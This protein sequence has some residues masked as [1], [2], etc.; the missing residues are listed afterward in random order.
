M[1]HGKSKPVGPAVKAGQRTHGERK[2]VLVLAGAFA[3]V[4][5]ALSAM[6]AQGAISRS[7]SRE[8]MGASLESVSRHQGT[9]RVLH[10]RFA[11]W[12]ELEARGERLR[13]GLEV[14]RSS[15][16]ESHW[17]LQLRDRESGLVCD[18]IHDLSDEGNAAPERNSCR[19]W[20]TQ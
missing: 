16:T 15:A 3:G 6:E 14:A 7:R 11:T 5:L 19:E 4:V 10:G 20:V 17:Y 13:D 1:Q 8:V 2:F 12:P 9:F 18:R